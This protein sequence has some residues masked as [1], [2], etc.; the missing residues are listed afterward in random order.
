MDDIKKIKREI[1]KQAKK[2]ELHYYWDIVGLSK[3]VIDNITEELESEGKIV[4]SK[5]TNYKI[6]MW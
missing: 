3:S 5:G 2:G 1:L 4:K 6:I